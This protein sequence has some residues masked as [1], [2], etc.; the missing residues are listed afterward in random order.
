MFGDPVTNPKGWDNV[1]L[2]KLCSFTKKNVKPEEI[3]DGTTY[4]GLEH[5]E[6][7]TGALITKQVVK[8][9]ELL[10]NKFW[11]NNSYILYGKLRP[12]L[13]KVALPKF[14]GICSTDIIP[15]L[16][17][18]H[19]TNRAFIATIM[20]SKGFVSFANERTSGANLPRISPKEIQNFPTI[21][22]PIKLQNQFAERVEQIEQQ[23]H[24]AQ[25]SLQKSEELFNSLLQR[26]FKGE[27]IQKAVLA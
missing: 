7:E 20:K 16:P 23:K 6:K 14:D 27:L 1:S 9:G 22:P 10:S 18:L 24:L 3:L 17:L 26:A 13:N 5:I 15:V 21:N 4:I 11:F 12:Y 2:N 8:A 25:Q 19:K